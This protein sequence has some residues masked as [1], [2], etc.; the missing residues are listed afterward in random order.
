MAQVGG[1]LNGLRLRCW[2]VKEVIPVEKII[3]SKLRT[4]EVE[5]KLRTLSK[6]LSLVP[7]E[8]SYQDR[9]N[10]KLGIQNKGKWL[11]YSL[12]QNR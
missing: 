7:L 8:R 2:E 4:R 6:E 9:T 5:V 12:V 10:A 1:T 3:P 11:T